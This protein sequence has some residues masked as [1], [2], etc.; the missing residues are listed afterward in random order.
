M[1]FIY[2]EHSTIEVDDHPDCDGEVFIDFDKDGGT[3]IR[4]ADA[5]G[6]I[7]A[8]QNAFGFTRD[9]SNRLEELLP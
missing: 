2:A 5:A 3:F 7:S 8:L 9:A 4:R 6:L 1:T